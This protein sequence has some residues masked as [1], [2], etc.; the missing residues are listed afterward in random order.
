M[1]VSPADM[2]GA[3]RPPLAAVEHPAA[4]RHRPALVIETE[5]PGAN[6]YD[7]RPVSAYKA[8]S[9]RA[10]DHTVRVGIRQGDRRAEILLAA[11]DLQR[12]VDD[13]YARLGLIQGAAT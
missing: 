6:A 2:P 13:L 1:T 9:V 7:G 10:G 5:P 8:H 12:L 3:P 11:P 4:T